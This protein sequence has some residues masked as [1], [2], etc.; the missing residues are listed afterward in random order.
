MKKQLQVRIYQDGRV[1]AETHGIT[2]KSCGDYMPL[3]ER[4][5]EARVTDTRYTEEY[6]MEEN[7]EQ[8]T[9]QEEVSL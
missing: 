4:M 7:R 6:Y 1:E 8:T 3:L 2:G 9:L 5:L